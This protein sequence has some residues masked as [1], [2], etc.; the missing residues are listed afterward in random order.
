MIFFDSHCHLDLLAEKLD[1]LQELNKCKKSKV[2]RILMPGVKKDN[3]GKLKNIQQVYSSSACKLD[4]ALGLHPYFMPQHQFEADLSELE[5]SLAG[6]SNCIAVGEIGL[7]FSLPDTG[8]SAH[9]NQISLFYQQLKLAKQAK[10]AVIIHHRK[11]ID[12]ISHFVKQAH[13]DYGGV[14]HAFSGSEQQAKKLI[15]LGFKLGI[16][17]TITYPRAKKTRQAIANVDA[18]HLLLETDAPDM[19]INGRQGQVNSPV[20]IIETFNELARLKKIDK[21]EL[22]DKLWQNTF[23]CFARLGS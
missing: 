6:D 19:P 1:L 12:K 21:T 16:G 10:L 14:V 4:Y 5:S 3:W 9:Q 7:D 23:D 22:S 13:F 15:D 8:A 2:K 20:F 17:G 18:E 11:S